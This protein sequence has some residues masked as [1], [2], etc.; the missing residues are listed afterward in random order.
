[1]RDILEVTYEEASTATRCSSTAN[2]Q[3]RTRSSISVLSNL[4][5]LRWR[6]RKRHGTRPAE[7]R[8]DGVDFLAELI[9]LEVLGL[10]R[11]ETG[12]D[13]DISDIS[14][15]A[16]LTRI[17]HLELRGNGN[18][19]EISALT[20]LRWF[21]FSMGS[22]GTSN[23]GR[24]EGQSD[25]ATNSYLDSCAPSSVAPPVGFKSAPI[26]QRNVKKT[27]ALDMYRA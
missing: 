23:P 21:D 7:Q 11:E 10:N 12:N 25:S 17:Y 2:T 14:A 3:K 4:T 20:T 16:N 5:S 1:M 6:N 24:S 27:I 18:L 13:C 15:V 22:C 8:Y 19:T 9:D 26:A